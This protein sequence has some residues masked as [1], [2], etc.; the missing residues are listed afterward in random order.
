MRLMPS[1]D[2]F[3]LAHESGMRLALGRKPRKKTNWKHSQASKPRNQSKPT[4]IV[5]LIKPFIILAVVGLTLSATKSH[6]QLSLNFS[7]S[8][9]GP[10]GQGATIQFNGTADSFQFNAANGPAFIPPFGYTS[11]YVGSQWTITS[12]FGGNGSADGSLGSVYNGPF[13]YGPITISP[14]GMDQT[15]NVTGPLGQLVITDINQQNLTGTVNWIQV[16][17]HDD[18]GSLNAALTVNV[19][20]LSYGGNI[21]DLQALAAN[22]VAG[23]DLT[24]QFSPGKTLTDLSS[25]SGPYETSFS[26]SISP[27]PEPTSLALGGLAGLGILF[28]R[29]WKK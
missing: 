15:A 25:G 19:T 17:T 5:N 21:S 24:F 1:H 12:V 9:G 14:D 10:P 2:C 26:G 3:S 4:K 27:V 8:P 16:A 7:S 23:M 22:G 18:A 11:Y 29:R 28:L 6:A 20:G 13:N